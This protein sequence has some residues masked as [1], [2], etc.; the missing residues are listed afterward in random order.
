VLA[1]EFAAVRVSV[2]GHANGERLLIEDVESGAQDY[3]DPL[4]QSSLCHPTGTDRTAWPQAS[5]SLD[6]RQ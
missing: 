6:E 4:E 3:L 2:D 1:N 5:L